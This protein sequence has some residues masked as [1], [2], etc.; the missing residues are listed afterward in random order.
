MTERGSTHR[1]AAAGSGGAGEGSAPGRRQ[2]VPWYELARIAR[3]E[4]RRYGVQDPGQARLGIVKDVAARTGYSENTI[5]R[6]LS[7]LSF[8]EALSAGGEVEFEELLALSLPKVEVIRRMGEED[9]GVSPAALAKE[10]LGRRVSVRRLAARRRGQWPAT[11]G[12]PAV[13]RTFEREA[14][15]LVQRRLELVTDVPGAARIRR[16]PFLLEIVPVDALV[17]IHREGRLEFAAALEVH[18]FAD[19][20]G[21]PLPLLLRLGQRAL[22]TAGFVTRF[23]FIVRGSDQAVAALDRLVGRL[24]IPNVGIIRM[25]ADGLPAVVRAPEGGPSPDRRDLLLDWA[26]E[27]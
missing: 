16:D 21:P 13:Q 10:V 22:V 19:A 4:A 11:P 5:S 25:A 15:D 20:A 1:T 6:A 27:R 9:P 17:Q 2:A 12:A 8:A 26:T 23:F 24:R 7:A 14:L 18:D 3:E